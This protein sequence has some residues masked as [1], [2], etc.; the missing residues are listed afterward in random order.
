MSSERSA[1]AC[2]PAGTNCEGGFDKASAPRA[3]LIAISQDV[4]GDKYSSVPLEDK[5]LTA[6]LLSFVGAATPHRK[7]CVSSKYFTASSLTVG[8]AGLQRPSRPRQEGARQSH[9]Q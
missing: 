1:S 5:R 3:N 8:P 4:A 6:C 7:T 2:I 9:L